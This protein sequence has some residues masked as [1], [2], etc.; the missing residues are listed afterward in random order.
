MVKHIFYLSVFI[1]MLLRYL[2]FLLR[3]VTKKP[4]QHY[5]KTSKEV[6]ISCLSS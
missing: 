2:V 3:P 4:Q 5:L 1:H 6:E